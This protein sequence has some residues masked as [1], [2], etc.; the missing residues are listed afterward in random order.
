MSPEVLPQPMQG[1]GQCETAKPCEYHQSKVAPVFTGLAEVGLISEFPPSSVWGKEHIYAVHEEAKRIPSGSLMEKL[2]A[3]NAYW[4]KHQQDLDGT[5]HHAWEV[6]QQQVKAKGKYGA[7]GWAASP[8]QLS[9]YVETINVLKDQGV[10]VSKV[11]RLGTASGV[12]TQQEVFALIFA[13]IKHQKMTIVDLCAP[14]L[15]ESLTI[16]PNV[17]AVS[18]SSVL[19]LPSE[20]KNTWPLITT[21][22]LE[23]FLPSVE[24]FTKEKLDHKASLQLK[25]DHLM[26]VYTALKPGGY[27]LSAIGTSPGA[28]RFHTVSEIQQSLQQSGFLK[29]HI[30]IV[31]TTDPF[32]YKNGKH[33]PCNYFVVAQKGTV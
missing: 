13:G 3:V 17:E 28:Q 6:W 2:Q 23:S 27:F 5:L 4:S 12:H 21:H 24:Q 16:V 29:D 9:Q 8:Q 1:L 11:L 18:V 31:P 20:W 7:G 19:S 10:D 32:D 26:Q 33:I 30:C 22:F 25:V 15:A 14:P